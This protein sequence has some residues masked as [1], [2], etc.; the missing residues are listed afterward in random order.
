M[1]FVKVIRVSDDGDRTKCI[2]CRLACYS[3]L[4]GTNPRLDV[5][6]YYDSNIV[7]LLQISVLPQGYAFSSVQ[8]LARHELCSGSPPHEEAV[9]RV[10]AVAGPG[11]DAAASMPQ[12]ETLLEKNSS[13]ALQ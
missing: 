12:P 2:G 8:S 6:Y 10:A 9:H 7:V 11:C 3:V 5:Q 4:T 1:R 13:L